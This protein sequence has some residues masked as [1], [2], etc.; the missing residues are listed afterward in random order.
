MLH[1]VRRTAVPPYRRTAVPP[2]RRTA[3]PPY[4]RTAVPP[5]GSLSLVQRAP[6]PIDE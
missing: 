1:L 4:R 6:P 2:Y 3:V 5:S